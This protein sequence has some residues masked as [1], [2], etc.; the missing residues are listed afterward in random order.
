MVTNIKEKNVVLLIDDYVPDST[1]IAAK[2][3]HELACELV[4]RG[5]KVTVIT[6]SSNLS[7]GYNS[8]YID[9]VEV[10]RFKL[11]PIKNCSFF[12]RAINESILPFKAWLN[13]QVHFKKR[14]VDLLISYSPSIFWG[15]YAKKLKKKFQC[16]SY[17][18]LRDFF[19]QWIID[20]KLIKANSI[21]AKYF[22]FIEKINYSSADVIGIQSIANIDYFKECFGE[23]YKTRLLFNWVKPETDKNNIGFKKSLGLED[24]I[25]FF[26]GGNIGKA[27][28]MSNLIRLAQ[29]LQDKPQ[30][31]FVFL[32]QGDE[33][34]L[35]KNMVIC[36]KIKNVSILP[37]VSQNIFKAILHEVDIGL[38]SLCHNHKSHNFPG[39]ILGY[40]VNNIP[41]L[42][43][44]NQGNDLQEIIREYSAGFVSINGD[45]DILYHNALALLDN[46]LLRKE[47]GINANRLLHAKFT[48]AAAADEVLNNQG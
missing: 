11:G 42:G 2:M 27:Q 46:P 1:K 41:I 3:M 29:R 26:Y 8:E 40:M 19:P 18:I 17:L 10:V 13:T 30:V 24:K 20:S 44:V 45:D 39:K 21:I 32:G 31:H 15:W 36:D 7:T 22:R 47:S 33:F 34:E 37:P 48:V 23:R 35:I 25:L 28:D 5:C 9:G 14:N 6:P 38:F 12:R 43:S 4:Q 16:P